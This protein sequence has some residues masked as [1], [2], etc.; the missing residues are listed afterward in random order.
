[1]SMHVSHSSNL[2]QRARRW[3][4]STKRSISPGGGCRPGLLL[5]PTSSRRARPAPR[6][7]PPFPPSNGVMPLP[8]TA[9]PC[10]PDTHLE[11]SEERRVGKECVSTCRSRWT[12]YHY[13]KKI[14][15]SQRERKSTKDELKKHK[16]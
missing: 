13:K 14:Q 8:P 9:S 10:S 16:D 6:T 15:M 11:R 5:P 1:M 12:T 7:P 2:R 3:R 4:S